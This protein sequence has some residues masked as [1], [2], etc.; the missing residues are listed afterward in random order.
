VFASDANPGQGTLA[1]TAT[2]TTVTV[3]PLA[4]VVVQMR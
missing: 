3:P 1:H 2:D 4:G